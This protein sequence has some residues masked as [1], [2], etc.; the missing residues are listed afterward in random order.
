MRFRFLGELKQKQC[1][2]ESEYILESDSQEPSETKERG[3]NPSE[4]SNSFSFCY[5][6]EENC[7]TEEMVR[8]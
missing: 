1:F 3:K 7:G 6:K 2:M 8:W 5:L 4:K